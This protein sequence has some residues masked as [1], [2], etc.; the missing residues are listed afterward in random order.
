MITRF[1]L[2]DD[3][4]DELQFFCEA[5]EDTQLALE[6]L[7]ASGG[8]EAIEKLKAHEFGDIPLILLDI[9]MHKLTGWETL[10]LLKADHQL[11]SP[12]VIMYSTSKDPKDPARA[13]AMGATGFISKPSTRQQL[14]TL[15]RVIAA[16]DATH[17]ET[18]I[19]HY[20][21]SC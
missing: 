19:T 15:A 9:N 7:T 12:A 5:I 20:E 2:I 1:L 16:S 10:A 14:N 8:T 6:C 21:A 13:K 11:R 3:D 18:I 17:P 4:P